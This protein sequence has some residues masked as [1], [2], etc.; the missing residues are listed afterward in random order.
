MHR[1]EGVPMCLNPLQFHCYLPTWSRESAKTKHFH[2]SPLL[3][4]LQT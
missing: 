3:T 1:E 4:K 2:Y